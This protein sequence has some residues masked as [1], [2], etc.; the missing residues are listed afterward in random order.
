MPTGSHATVQFDAP[1]TV[2]ELITVLTVLR[3][4]HGPDAVVRTKGKGIE[5]N[6]NG[7]RVR[8]ISVEADGNV[9]QHMR[10]TCTAD[11]AS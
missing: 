8:S 1:A 9:W 2:G 6:V 5:L 11:D 4:Q 3:E 7:P 10:I